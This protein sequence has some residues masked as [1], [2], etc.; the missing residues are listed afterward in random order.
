MARLVA[1]LTTMYRWARYRGTPGTRRDGSSPHFDM[2]DAGFLWAWTVEAQ[3]SGEQ[4]GDAR[5]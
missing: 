1:T 2:S 4:A 5:G 3:K